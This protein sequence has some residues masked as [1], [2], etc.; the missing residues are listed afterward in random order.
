MAFVLETP[1]ASR[2]GGVN[3]ALLFGLAVVGTALPAA[4]N[5]LLVQRVGA[6]NASLT[7]FFLPAFAV[8]FGV[9]ILGE[10][11]TISMMIGMALIIAGSRIVTRV[12]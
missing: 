2:F 10:T 11:M 4:L 3:V 12:R 1:Q 8:V 6:T 5:N 7:A 9:L